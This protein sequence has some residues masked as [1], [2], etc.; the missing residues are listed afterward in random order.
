MD[1]FLVKVQLIHRIKERVTTA[2]AVKERVS[3][4]V[5]SDISNTRQRPVRR[6][7]DTNLTRPRP[8]RRVD[9]IYLTRPQLCFHTRMSVSQTS[10][11]PFQH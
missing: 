3:V 1:R 4:N 7:G 6:A 9:D 11:T 5:A 8:A 2:A 10:G